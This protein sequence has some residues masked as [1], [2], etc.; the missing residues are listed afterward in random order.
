MNSFQLNFN[1]AV[2][3]ATTCAISIRID[4]AVRYDS[5]KKT[6]CSKGNAKRTFN[7]PTINQFITSSFENQLQHFHNGGTGLKIGDIIIARMRGYS[8]WPAKIEKFSANKKSFNCY[9]YGTHNSGPISTK[10]AIPFA[11][12]YPTIRLICL[13]SP[14]CFIKGIKEIETEYGIPSELS[15]LREIN[16]I[17]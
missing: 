13:K 11:D 6:T 2:R 10:N 17:E 16:S 7:M 3:K 1:I 15:C 14:P 8:P 9:F 5:S 12:A 4:P